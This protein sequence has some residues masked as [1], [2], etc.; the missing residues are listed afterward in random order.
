MR[1]AGTRAAAV[2]SRDDGRVRRRRLTAFE[3]GELSVIANKQLLATGYDCP[4]VRHVI[5]ATRI[6]SPVLFEQIVG[7]ASRGPRVGGHA[8]STVWQF[9][10]H[11]AMHG[12]P[13]SYGRYRDHD[14]D[15]TRRTG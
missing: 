8:R 13:Q 2:S 14:W 6:G 3:R 7:R 5:L 9:E 15:M 11:V 4:A 10:D 1:C 12:L